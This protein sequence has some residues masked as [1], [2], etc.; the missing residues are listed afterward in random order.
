V[1]ASSPISLVERII[2]NAETMLATT[3]HRRQAERILSLAVSLRAALEPS[4]A[5]G[6]RCAGCG[7]MPDTPQHEFACVITLTDR[8]TPVDYSTGPDR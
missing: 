6:W 8:S 3:Y 2:E 5:D 1:N 4:V 7:H